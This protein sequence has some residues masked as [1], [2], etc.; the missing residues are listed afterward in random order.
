MYSMHRYF[1]ALLPPALLMVFAAAEKLDRAEL[2]RQLKLK[3]PAKWCALLVLL[4]LGLAPNLSDLLYAR[5][6][7]E[8]KLAA[9]AV[10]QVVGRNLLFTTAP[11]PMLLYYNRENPPE[12]V[13]LVTEYSPGTVALRLDMLRLAQER[14]REGRPVFATGEIM[15][16]LPHAR[17]DADYELILDFRFRGLNRNFPSLQLFRLTALRFVESASNRSG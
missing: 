8:D 7:D 1:L 14:L 4:V 13:Y 16:H 6:N 11:E 3:E 12:T 15:R 9:T 5:A 10:G 2:A 17:V